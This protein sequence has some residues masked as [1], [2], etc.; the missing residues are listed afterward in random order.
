[1]LVYIRP[2]ASRVLEREDEYERDDMR[3]KTISSGKKKDIISRE[4]KGESKKKQGDRGAW[5]SLLMR[6]VLVTN[7]FYSPLQTKMIAVADIKTNADTACTVR[8][9]LLEL[10]LELPL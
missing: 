3:L 10:L 1:M 9:L 6:I 4:E 5:N 7:H 2:H 8:G